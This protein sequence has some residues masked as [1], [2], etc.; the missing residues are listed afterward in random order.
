MT[1]GGQVTQRPSTRLL[2]QGPVQTNSPASVRPTVK[3]PKAEIMCFL[4]EVI[5]HYIDVQGEK[6]LL[7][8]APSKL[9]PFIFS[10]VQWGSIPHWAAHSGD[11]PITKRA[12]WGIPNILSQ[13]FQQKPP[14]RLDSPCTERLQSQSSETEF[15]MVTQP[16]VTVTSHQ[17]HQPLQASGVTWHLHLEQ[18]VLPSLP[19]CFLLLSILNAR[20]WSSVLTSPPCA[21]YPVLT[22]QRWPVR[23]TNMLTG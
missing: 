10:T 17:G 21:C 22:H 5:F 8:L 12:S 19:S 20:L 6:F 9:F 23:L 3:W 2:T 14:R 18:P 13:W 16:T 15:P 7:P 11:Q 4:D 1:D